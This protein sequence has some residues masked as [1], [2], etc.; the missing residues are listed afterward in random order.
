MA[1]Y[2]LVSPTS[3][4]IRG[5]QPADIRGLHSILKNEGCVDSEN[6]FTDNDK[7]IALDD[8]QTRLAHQNH[9]DKLPSADILVCIAKNKYLLADAKFRQENDRNKNLAVSELQKKLEAS[10][11]LVMTDEIAFANSFYVL[12]TCKF[13]TE[14]RLR[15][16][17]QQFINS[18]R[19][20]FVNA[21]E[22]RDLF[23]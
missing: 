9:T 22:F 6:K 1:E 17:K 4:R 20:R 21:I 23:E 3:I 19:F 5:M 16:L 13:L 12:F 14:T 2:K 15:R 18:P 8:V 7:A 11:S 10:R